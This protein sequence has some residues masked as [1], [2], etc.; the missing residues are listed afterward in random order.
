MKVMPDLEFIK[1]L[2]ET[3][4]DTLKKCYQCASCS[5]ACPLSSDQ[6]PFPRKEMIWAQWGLKENIFADPDVFLC[7]QCGDCTE[8]CPRGAKPA[9]VLGAIRA[10][11][12]TS[13]SWPSWLA[14]AAA[15]V[16]NLPL[17]VGVPSIIV[18]ILW[19]LSGGMYFP[20][21]D[22]FTRYGYTQFFGHW[23]FKWYPKNTTFIISIMIPCAGI[24]V[25]S[26]AR[27][28]V[29]MWKAMSKKA[30]ITASFRP[31]ALMFLG[32]FLW[33]SL[34]ETMKHTRF[35]ECT[36]NTDRVKGHLPLLLGF[37]G[38]FI[39]TCWSA[40]RQDFLG[41]IW[42]SFHGPLPLTDPFKTLANISAIALLYGIWMLWSNRL[43][44]EK[45][46]KA[47]R[48]FYD[49]FLIWEITAVG[50]TGLGA[51]LLRWAGVPTFGYI[52]YFM[53]LVSIV[54]LFLYMPYTKFAHIIYRTMAMCFEKY[55]V[56]RFAQNT[57][58]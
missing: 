48:T 57:K 9:E 40:F 8:I 58:N 13:Y 2:K 53:H 27:G 7:H 10:Y 17:L 43:K 26:V 54:M 56:S 44:L 14:Q 38:A 36:A 41:L 28:V 1:S 55:R 21:A 4:G 51:E 11:I 24:A 19:F 16:K 47:S 12:Y 25:F 35:R 32:E 15:S 39:L 52:V 5:V 31:S 6:N 18:L 49:W 46:G 33:P 30:M 20:S 3:G 23:N 37:I 50:V 45:R 29:R 34:V 22:F 42:P